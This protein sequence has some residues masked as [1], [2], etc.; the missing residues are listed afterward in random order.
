M[1]GVRE[2]FWG[3]ELNTAKQCE[4]ATSLPE[5]KVKNVRQYFYTVYLIFEDNIQEKFLLEL[6][7]T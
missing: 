6:L 5:T 7:E 2:D 1:L 3:R 4:R